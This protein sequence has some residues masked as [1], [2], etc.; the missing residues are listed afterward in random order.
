MFFIS[1][2]N[3]PDSST[4]KYSITNTFNTSVDKNYVTKEYGI[5]DF[6]VIEYWGFKIILDFIVNIPNSDVSKHREYF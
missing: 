6:G 4:T 2:Y 1:T 3:I 5:V